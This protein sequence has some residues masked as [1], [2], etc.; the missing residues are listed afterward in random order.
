MLCWW[1]IYINWHLSLHSVD[2]ILQTMN[3]TDN[4]FQFMYEIENSGGPFSWYTCFPTW[5]KAFQHLSL[6][7]TSIFSYFYFLVLAIHLIKKVFFYFFVN[8]T[9]N[10]CLDSIS[11]NNEI[12]YLKAIAL[13]R[14]YN[15]SIV[16]KALFKLQNP[17]TSHSSPSNPNINVILPFFFQIRVSL[18]LKFLN[19][20]FLK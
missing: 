15:L 17:R 19:I 7:K 11:F 18:L 8:R 10:I 3:S 1:H 16:D 20:I 4:N 14:G 2:H 6:T 5:M 12:Q 13:D 9:L